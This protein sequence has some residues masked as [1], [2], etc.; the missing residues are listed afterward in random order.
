MI[1]YCYILFSKKLNKFYIGS[2]SNSVD[3]RMEQHLTDVYGNRKF[4]HAAKDWVLFHK[5]SCISYKQAM[6]I[7]KHIKNMKST[8]YIQNLKKYPEI[9][10]KLLERYK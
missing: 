5:I 6:A 1:Y 7:E 2:T 3:A 9:S 10:Q 4:T 8:S